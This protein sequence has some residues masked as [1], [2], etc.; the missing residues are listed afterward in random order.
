MSLLLVIDLREKAGYFGPPIFE[1][2]QM[3]RYLLYHH[4]F[5]Q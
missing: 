3:A 2:L 4:R 1:K 5:L